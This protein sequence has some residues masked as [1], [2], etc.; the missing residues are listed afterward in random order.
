[1]ETV[2]CEENSKTAVSFHEWESLGNEGKR[3]GEVGHGYDWKLPHQ[4]QVGDSYDQ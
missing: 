4:Q 2:S 3:L 1:M